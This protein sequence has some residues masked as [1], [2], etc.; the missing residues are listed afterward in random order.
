MK[1]WVVSVLGLFLAAPL[2]A[3]SGADSL[4]LVTLQRLAV[5]QDARALQPSLLEEAARL[6]LANLRAQR[7]PQLAVLGQG[8]VQSAAPSIPFDLPNVEAPAS[9]LERFQI[10]AEADHRLY[11]G[12]RLSRR[13]DLERAALAEQQAGVAVSLYGLQQAVTEVYFAAL[14]AESQVAVLQLQDGDLTARLATVRARVRG[15]AALA[16]DAAALE[17]EAIR[18]TQRR[19]E[20]EANAR[21]ARTILGQLVGRTRIDQ[22]LVVPN[23]DAPFQDG[24]AADTLGRPELMRIRRTQDRLRAE[25]RLA[26][27]QHRPV[28]S[29]FGQGGIGRPSPFDPF[30]DTL[31]PYALAGVRL[32]WAP[33]DWGQAARSSDAA[34]IHAQIAQTEADALTAQI[35][36]E[37][38]NDLAQIARLDRARAQDGQ[39]IAL[40]EEILRVAG[41]Q[42]DEGVLLS[43]DYADRVSDLAEARLIA[44]RHRIERVRAQA[45]VLSLLGLP[46]PESP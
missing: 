13:A 15:G 28:V 42:L 22:P 10:Q 17:A 23:L 39:V 18:V 20:A 1:R 26:S 25:A 36:R 3:Q 7:L 5:E 43:A 35:E 29:L 41:R 45:R 2:A 46:L 30:G 14:L 21:A 9:P 31:E 33:I 24:L 11:D 8:T 12:G 32:R 16:A 44:A 27:A 37:V 40:R 34:R 4:R 19:E 6:R 38:Q